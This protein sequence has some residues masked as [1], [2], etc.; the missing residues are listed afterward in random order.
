L[1]AKMNPFMKFLVENDKPT[2]DG[3][4]NALADALKASYPN[5]ATK[6]EGNERPAPGK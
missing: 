2:A 6:G 5:R 3:V 1:E 4:A